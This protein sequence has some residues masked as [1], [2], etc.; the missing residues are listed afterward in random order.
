[1]WSPRHSY[2]LQVRSLRASSTRASS[3]NFHISYKMRLMVS[4]ILFHFKLLVLKAYKRKFL[5]SCMRMNSD[6]DE[7]K[8]NVL[9][10]YY[11][12]MRKQV[13][14]SL[15]QYACLYRVGCYTLC[16]QSALIYSEK[17]RMFERL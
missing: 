16:D 11:L 2:Q 8:R 15:L 9:S 5:I 17:L 12:S 3:C 6:K 14:R 4:Y 7:N 1:M 10:T 13:S